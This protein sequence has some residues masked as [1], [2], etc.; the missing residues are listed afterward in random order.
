M[1]S[2]VLCLY[3]GSLFQKKSSLVLLLCAITCL[4]LALT[5]SYGGILRALLR[6]K[7]V[8]KKL[9]TLLMYV[10]NWVTGLLISK[11]LQLLL[12][13][14]QI[15]SYTISQSHSD[16]LFFSTSWKSLLRKLLVNIYNFMQFQII[17]S[18][19]VNLIALNSSQYQI[20]VLLSLTLSNQG[21][22]RT[23][24]Q[25]L[26]HLTLPSSFLY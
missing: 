7:H 6:T 2:Q 1:K 18:T 3:F 10:L 8:W 26:W 16:L 22:S 15:K 14:N 12:F 24:W 21:G 25:V 17:S 5:N 19:S 9:S 20:L 11:Y 13:W 4:P 23:I